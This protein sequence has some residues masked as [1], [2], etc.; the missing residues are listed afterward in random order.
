MASPLQNK[1]LFPFIAPPNGGKGTQTK[2]LTDKYGLPTFDMGATFRRIRNDEPDSELAQELQSFMDRGA[3]VPTET[4]T[5][6]FA[7]GLTDLAEENPKTKGFILDGFPRNAGQAE[8]LAQKVGEWGA[9]IAK[10]IYLNVPHETIVQRASGRRMCSQNDHRV[11]NVTFP[12][13]MPKRQ[14][15]SNGEPVYD[16]Y[17]K[18]VWLCDEDGADLYIRKDDLPENVENRLKVYAEETAPI[19]KFFKDK[20]LLVEIKGDSPLA[21]VTRDI[22]NSIL[23][24]L[25]YAVSSVKKK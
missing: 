6:V 2:I 19:L 13:Q 4:V 17:G 15:L 23:P 8:A 22:E 12:E 21:T 25:Q 9:R 16:Q 3:L 24:D 18:P 11:Y 20:G 1:L 14:K 10:V 7:K 5:R